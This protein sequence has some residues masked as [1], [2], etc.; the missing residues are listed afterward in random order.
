MEPRARTGRW[1]TIREV[2]ALLAI[3]GCSSSTDP[4]GAAGPAHLTSTVTASSTSVPVGGIVTAQWT[5]E[6]TGSEPFH[7]AFGFPNTIG[8]GL[9]ISVTPAASVLQSQGSDLVFSVNDSL[10]LPPHGQ[11]RLNAIFRGVAVGT[12]TLQGCLPPD[13]AETDGANCASTDVR[14]VSGL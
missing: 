14:V 7:H 4:G 9:E 11:I 13:S 2:A 12:A 10:N 5:I 8:Y 6:N 3:V 1:T